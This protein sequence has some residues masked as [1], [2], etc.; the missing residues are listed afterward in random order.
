MSQFTKKAIVASF[1]KLLNERPFDKIAVKDIVEDCGVNRNTFYYYY[2]DI[3]ALLEDV[4]ETEA[5]DIIDANLTYSS[6]QEGLIHSTRFALENKRAIY[7]IYNSLN[8]EA[9]ERYLYRVT[10]DMMIRFVRQQAEGLS[11]SEED[12]R[13]VTLFYKHAVLGIVQ[14]WLQNGMKEEPEPVIHRLGKLLDGNIRTI[15]ER[16]SR[17]KAAR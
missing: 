3:Y 16:V 17:E 13:L 5:A 14:E 6:W 2:R 10:E 1:V 9:L 11:V 15:F 7:H 4:F 8:R 12:V